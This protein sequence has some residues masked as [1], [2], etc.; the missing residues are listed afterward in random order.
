MVRGET[1]VSIMFTWLELG[2][3]VLYVL[4]RYCAVTIIP[5]RGNFIFNFLPQTVHFILIVLVSLYC[6]HIY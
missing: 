6:L 5:S 1:I 4:E 2:C 3:C